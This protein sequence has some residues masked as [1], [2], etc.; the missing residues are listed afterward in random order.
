[1]YLVG[2]SNCG[3]TNIM[4]SQI[5]QENGLKFEN[6]YMYSK[7]RYQPKCL[8]LKELLKPI[9]CLG[10]YKFSTCEQILHQR[11]ILFIFDDVASDN[12]DVIREYFSIGRH[13]HIDSFYKLQSYAKLGKYLI[14]DNANF[15]F[16]FAQDDRNLRHIYD[17][18]IGSDMLLDDFES[19]CSAGC[20]DLYGFLRI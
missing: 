9:K 17:Y 16:V 4:I 15:L 13:N 19:I 2:L 3:K 20:K 18:H 14:G 10:C 1:M 12:Q 5:E 11:K 6:I 8:Y 7:S